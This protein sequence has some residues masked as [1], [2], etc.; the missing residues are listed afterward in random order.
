MHCPEAALPT[1]SLLGIIRGGGGQLN[2]G[3]NLLHYDLE[4]NVYDVSNKASVTFTVSIYFRNGN[5]WTNFPVLARQSHIFITGRIFGI[6]ADT[7]RLAIGV[8]DIYFIPNLNSLTTAPITPTSSPGKQK[9]AE[10]WKSRANPLIPTK[11]P[12]TLTSVSDSQPLDNGRQICP[13]TETHLPMESERSDEG[14]AKDAPSDQPTHL[15]DRSS[16]D[17]IPRGRPPKRSPKFPK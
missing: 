1:V 3:S 7:P 13:S 9:Q 5:R 10:R 17:T 14:L 12:G 15:E 11:R 16:A 2:N 8:D 6:T 4:S